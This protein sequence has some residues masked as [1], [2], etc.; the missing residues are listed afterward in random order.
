MTT[1]GPSLGRRRGLAG[2][3]LVLAGLVAWSAYLPWIEER[4]SGRALSGWD[5]YQA[6]G[7]QGLN[8]WLLSEFFREGVS[9]FFTGLA[10]VVA[11]TVLGAVALTL[12]L[13]PR[14][15]PP[16]T[17]RVSP[18]ALAVA[19][20]IGLAAMALPL[21]NIAS[22]VGTGPEIPVFGIGWGST[23]GFIA[24]AAWL[25]VTVT[26][27]VPIKRRRAAMPR[28]AR[29]TLQILVTIL[30]VLGFLL[31]AVLPC[32]TK[33][34]DAA[35]SACFAETSA[36][37]VWLGVGIGGALLGLVLTWAGPPLLRHRRARRV[38]AV[39]SP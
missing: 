12:L 33:E 38:A 25:L 13:W 15:R 7:E 1:A 11:G 37:K 27:A 10:V 22:L 20:V 26:S 21:V 30:L 19:G 35:V 17:G 9:P 24:A 29:I 39:Q 16:D 14:S 32:G 31:A 2:L 8:R 28:G 18:G 23:V 34:T 5:V 36:W 3:A 4:L 6:A